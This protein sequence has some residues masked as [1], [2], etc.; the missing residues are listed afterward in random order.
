[1]WLA[2]LAHT[3]LPGVMQKPLLSVASDF[4]GVHSTDLAV[5]LVCSP[6][7]LHKGKL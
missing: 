5:S 7:F 1:M 3:I 6:T 4:E 2:V